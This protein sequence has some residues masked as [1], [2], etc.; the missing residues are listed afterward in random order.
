MENNYTGVID[1][2]NIEEIVGSLKVSFVTN[3]RNQVK[4]CMIGL[5]SYDLDTLIKNHPEASRSLFVN[6]NLEYIL[7]DSDYLFSIITPLYATESAPKRLVEEKVMDHLQDTL[8]AFEDEKL[9]GTKAALAWKE[10]KGVDIEHED[11]A[12]INERDKVKTPSISILK[13]MGWLTGL[14]HKPIIGEKIQ[15]TIHF[16]YD[17]LEKSKAHSVLPFHQCLCENNNNASGPHE[18]SRRF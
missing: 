14:Q 16:D 17:C 2:N 3:Y 15:I 9:T 10:Q 6:G 7:P 12:D 11:D 1:E 13:V 4:E 8:N 18:D 5:Q